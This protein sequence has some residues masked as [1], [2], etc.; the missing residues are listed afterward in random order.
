ML[1]DGQA[2]R[3]ASPRQSMQS[4]VVMIPEN[5]RQEGL[6][7]DFDV[8]ENLSIPRLPQLSFFGF[9]NEQQIVK[10]AKR[11]V[12]ELAIKT[13]S[14]RQPVITL[15]GGNQQKVSLGK[16]FDAAA[17]VWIF[18]EP[19]QGIDV[20]TKSEIYGIMQR[21]AATGAAIWFISSDLR[22]LTEIADRIYVMRDFSIVAEFRKPFLTEEVLASMLGKS[23]Q[24][25]V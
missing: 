14:G 20:E 21:M 1:L 24:K 19:T 7:S 3:P 6:V 22:E 4:G 2:F 15:S 10:R 18:D 16:W 25:R 12:G 17:R 8:I 9:R 5:R 11:I 23:Q 13:T